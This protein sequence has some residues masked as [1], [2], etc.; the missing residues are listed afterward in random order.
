[1]QSELYRSER[2]KYE[3]MHAVPGYSLGPGETHVKTFLNFINPGES[4]IDFGCGT[5]DAARKLADLGHPVALVDIVKDPL[6]ASHGLVDRFFEA[7]LHDLPAELPRADWGFCCDVM[8]HLPEDWI[9]AALAGMKAKVNKIFFAISGSPDGW[10]HHINDTLHLT[11]KPCEWWPDRIVKHWPSVTRLD[12]SG[13]VFIMAA[14]DPLAQEWKERFDAIWDRGN[15]RLGSMGKRMVPF[16][17]GF[18]RPGTEINVYCSGTG[19]D[20]VDYYQ[21]GITGINMVDVSDH[22]LEPEAQ[23]LVGSGV[24]MTVD[25]LWDLPGDFPRC[26]WGLCIDALMCFP[27]EKLDESLAQIRRTA[28][29]LI[30]EVYDWADVRCGMDLTT[31]K[32]DRDWWLNKLKQF[33]AD[34]K[35]YPSE[36][37]RRYVFVCRGGTE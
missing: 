14:S 17:L 10:G 32:G 12:G 31:V 29:N 8:E 6:R 28:D 24:T 16:V 9:P 11:V 30:V 18:I 4:V 22:A 3:R 21:A 27:P 37:D 36:A 5:G 19:R 13:D 34:V 25:A 35:S 1:M 7:S 2:R 33:Y 23:S 26:E 20:V 15:Y